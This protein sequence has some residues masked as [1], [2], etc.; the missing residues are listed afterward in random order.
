MLREGEEVVVGLARLHQRWPFLASC[1]GL[2]ATRFG[3]F[4]GDQGRAFA[5]PSRRL[6]LLIT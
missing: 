4:R 3:S 1:F 6:G 2:E 5:R